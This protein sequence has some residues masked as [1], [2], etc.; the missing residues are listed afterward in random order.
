VRRAGLSS[1]VVQYCAH[2]HVNIRHLGEHPA[3]SHEIVGVP[4]HVRGRHMG[5]S[6]GSSSARCEP[7]NRIERSGELK[8]T[9]RAADVQ[10]RHAGASSAVRLKRM[11]ANPKTSSANPI[12]ARITKMN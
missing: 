9:F 7:P 5:F 3:E 11:K 2:I 6:A 1:D 8:L 12:R 4:S 10:K